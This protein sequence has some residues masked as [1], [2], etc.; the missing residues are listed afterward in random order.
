MSSKNP[1]VLFAINKNTWK[2]FLPNYDRK[3]LSRFQEVRVDVSRLKPGQWEKI[4][5]E[6][7]PEVLVSCW[8]TPRLPDAL[9]R[10]KKIPL[11]YVN[12]LTGTVKGL[13]SRELIERGLLISNWGSTISHTIA[14]HA[15]L[16]VLASLRS[17]PLWRG[18]MDG[19][20]RKHITTRS[21]HG[22]RVGIHGFGA[23]ARHLISLLK[24][25]GVTLSV[26]SEGVPVAMFAQHGVRR[27]K[28]LEELVSNID[29]MI[30]C[31]AWTPKTQGSVSAKILKL[32]PKDAVFV[33]VGRGYVVD[34]AALGKLARA[35]KLNVGLDVY[36]KEPLP[37][38]SPL[39]GL[40]NAILSP[41]IAGP[42]HDAF[43]LCGDNVISNLKS[44][45]SGRKKEIK[46]VVTLEIYDRTT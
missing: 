1:V 35:G 45:L 10:E 39:Q 44:Y 23:I 4:L 30:E 37:H 38:D 13:T 17:I 18:H 32:L 16:L 36:Q 2:N 34:E 19:S 3:K 12:H 31:E 9:V 29:I 40:D 21:L 8:E 14:E 11:K 26:Y 24:P 46:G 33:N 6:K 25:F 7:Q 43:P 27:C 41:H 5:I 42:T 22:K 28:S 20:E 15:L